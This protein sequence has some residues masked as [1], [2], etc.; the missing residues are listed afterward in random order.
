MHVTVFFNG[1]ASVHKYHIIVFWKLLV[2][3][4]NHLTLYLNVLGGAPIIEHALPNIVTE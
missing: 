2:D 1:L 4:F 3:F